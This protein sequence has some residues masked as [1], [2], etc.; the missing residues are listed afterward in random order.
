M[1][2][3]YLLTGLLALVLAV[4]TGCGEKPAA[5]PSE[6]A[7]QPS[8]E[9]QAPETDQND[10]P[11]VDHDNEQPSESVDNVQG[12]PK[13]VP[14]ENRNSGT[15]EKPAGD[16]ENA[17]QEKKATIDLYY[18][19]PELLDLKKASGEITFT[20]QENK[21]AKAFEGLQK[22]ADEKLVPLWHDSIKLI[23]IKFDKG[24]LTLDIVMPP[25]A[26]LGSGGELFAIE[27]LKNTFFQF[28]EVK[29]IQLLVEGKKVESLMGHVDLEHPM[30]RK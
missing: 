3:K 20:D 1:N 13:E 7:Q 25:E 12:G 19:D 27:A 8:E 6:P 14:A 15:Q 18:T 16:K 22:S 28:E 4:S 9:V 21:Y 11:D 26:N 2:R 23:S 5:A 30:T 24:A 29:S 10:A 17:S